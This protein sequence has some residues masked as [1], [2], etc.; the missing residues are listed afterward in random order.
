[1]KGPR[2]LW[3]VAKALGDLLDEVV[4]VGGMVRE[5]LVT[6]PAAGPARVTHDVDCVAGAASYPE[7]VQLSERLRARGFAECTDDGAPI[8]RWVVRD[9][10]VDVMPV[11]PVV[12]GFS[13]VWYPSAID[14]AVRVDNAGAHAR[15]VD[16]PHF[17]AT[18]IEAFLG[19]GQK[20]FYHHDMEDIVALVDGRPELTGEIRGAPKELREFVAKTLAEWLGDRRFVDVVAGHLRGDAASQARKP[21]ILDRLREIAGI[22]PPMQRVR[23]PVSRAAA[24]AMRADFTQLPTYSWLSS[25]DLE[26]VAYDR[27]HSVLLIRFRSGGV[28]QYE[29][30]PANVYGG[31]MGAASHGRYFHQ[32]IKG[33]YEFQKLA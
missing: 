31:L 11:D 6:D 14:H 3:L 32:W 22:A 20:D 7:Y 15:V 28:Y 10:R 33:R 5:L 12:L 27:R 19:R 23:R 26:A 8:C 9:V 2:E 4:F 13:N 29:N 17:L 21:M 25:S 16:A 18:K 30:V 1:M 24:V